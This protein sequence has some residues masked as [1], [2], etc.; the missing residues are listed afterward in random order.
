MAGYAA[1]RPSVRCKTGQNVVSRRPSATARPR[2]GR[3]GNDAL[4]LASG[5]GYTGGTTVGSGSGR[6]LFAVNGAVPTTSALT[7]NGLAHFAQSSTIGSLAGVPGTVLID[8]GKPLTVG[9][10]NTDTDFG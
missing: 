10:D 9:A 4:K 8:S 3:A 1:A 6:L 7:V 2:V 5:S